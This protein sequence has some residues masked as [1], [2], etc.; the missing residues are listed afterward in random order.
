MRAPPYS[1][2]CPPVGDLKCEAPFLNV[3]NFTNLIPRD[4]TIVKAI[5]QLSKSNHNHIAAVLTRPTLATSVAVDVDCM[6]G[7]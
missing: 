5:H 7:T 6:C 4:S 3:T 2:V 1:D